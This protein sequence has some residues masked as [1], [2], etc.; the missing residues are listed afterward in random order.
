[1]KKIIV[2]SAINF[3]EGGPLTILKECLEYLSEYLSSQY[4]IIALVHNKK[5]LNIEYIEYIEYKKS[6]KSWFYRIYYEYFHF[7]FLSRKI[8]PHL[9]LALHDITPNV[10]ADIRA[11]YCHNPSPFY[12]FSLRTLSYNYKGALF[13][14]FY[15]YLYQI[16]IHKN[17]FVI[18]QQ[19]W[20]RN[21][22]KKMYG[23]SNIVVSYPEARQISTL[24]IQVESRPI[25]TF[26]YPAFPRV[27]KNFEVVAEAAKLLYAQGRSDFE[28]IFTIYGEENKYARNIVTKY[29]NI[30]VISFI[31]LKTRDEIYKLYQ[32]ING[33][34]FSSKLETWG[35]PISEFKAFGKPMLIA[36]LPYAHET[37]GDYDKVVFF[38]PNA[39]QQLA[40]FMKAVMDGNLIYDGNRRVDVQEPFAKNWEQL[41]NILLS[42]NKAENA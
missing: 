2:V 3:F 27:F 21:N 39:P 10:N 26:L 16:N 42:P 1:M 14:L 24:D 6:R 30:P 31:G 40:K 12:S 28:V 18:V 29:K 11:V 38:D 9:W 19:D 15:K 17:N 13:I 36:D 7:I 35:L 33:L 23:V 8:R 41:F 32:Q 34:I 20:I 25:T 22:F 5:L 4:K 37:L